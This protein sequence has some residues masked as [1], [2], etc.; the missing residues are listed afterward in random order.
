MTR[1]P[2]L[3]DATSLFGCAQAKGDTADDAAMPAAQVQKLSTKKFHDVSS[4]KLKNS[5]RDVRPPMALTLP[6]K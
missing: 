1:V 6:L 3:G 4:K 5:N 2:F